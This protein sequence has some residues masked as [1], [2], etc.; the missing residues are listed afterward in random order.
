MLA[1]RE[2]R[3]ETTGAALYERWKNRMALSGK[4]RESYK[5]TDAE[6]LERRQQALLRLIK[7]KYRRRIMG[8]TLPSAYRRI[9]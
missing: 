8:P 3:K 7:T 1:L 9:K 2:L 4:L 5:F 6:K